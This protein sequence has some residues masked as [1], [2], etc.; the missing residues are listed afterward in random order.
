MKVL[1]VAARVIWAVAM[2]VLC[3][4]VGAVYGWQHHGLVGA[5]AVGFIGLVVGVFLASPEFVLQL[6]H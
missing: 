4:A 2:I 5:V 6:L 3:T 1:T